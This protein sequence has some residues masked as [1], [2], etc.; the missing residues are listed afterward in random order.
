VDCLGA[1]LQ[2]ILGDSRQLAPAR[3]F[4]A[5]LVRIS[6]A[7][8]SRLVETKDRHQSQ[9]SERQLFSVGGRRQGEVPKETLPRPQQAT[10]PFA[11]PVPGKFEFRCVMHHHDAP[12]ILCSTRRRAQVRLQDRLWRNAFIAKEAIR[13][14]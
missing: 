1:A 6:L 14:L 4:A 12:V 5:G 13:G 11:L 9:Q 3:R 8:R 7:P 10:Q 2:S